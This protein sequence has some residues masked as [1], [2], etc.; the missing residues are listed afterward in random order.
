MGSE[1]CIRDRSCD[2]QEEGGVGNNPR[3]S[4]DWPEKGELLTRILSATAAIETPASLSNEAVLVLSALGYLPPAAAAPDAAAASKKRKKGPRPLSSDSIIVE[5]DSEDASR[6]TLTQR[7]VSG[8]GRA[9]SS[10]VDGESAAKFIS[11][12][13]VVLCRLFF[14]TEVGILSSHVKCSAHMGGASFDAACEAVALVCG[15]PEGRDKVLCSGLGVLLTDAAHLL[16]LQV[17]VWW[18]TVKNQRRVGC[19]PEAGGSGVTSLSGA[20][21]SDAELTLS[22]AEVELRT[23][24]DETSVVASFATATQHSSSF[25]K[26]SKAAKSSPRA[27]QTWLETQSSYLPSLLKTLEVLAKHTPASGQ[28][29]AAQDAWAWHIFVSGLAQALSSGMQTLRSIGKASCKDFFLRALSCR[30]PQLVSGL[31]L[32]LRCVLLLLSQLFSLPQ[33]LTP[34]L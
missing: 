2:M 22:E 1:M 7:A 20:V 23:S 34:Y 26:A 24:S 29:K 6:V 18:K 17:E 8:L 3:V 31:A 9:F 5:P 33:R 30:L 4:S 25:D 12:G 19:Y 27:A 11:G 13:G 32:L 10:V 16:L 21:P 14:G 28:A 15:S